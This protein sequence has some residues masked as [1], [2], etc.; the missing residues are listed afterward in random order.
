MQVMV[1]FRY[2]L[3][4]KELVSLVKEGKIPMERIDD[5]VER[6]LRVKF[7]AGL[8]EFNFSDRPSLETIGC[9]VTFAM[10]ISPL[11]LTPLQPFHL[12]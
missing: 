11:N 12:W 4:V 10:V 5:A 2:E 1:P 8:F 7:V 9:K 3:F 6:I